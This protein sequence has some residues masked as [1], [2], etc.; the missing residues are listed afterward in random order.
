MADLFANRRKVKAVSLQPPPET[1]PIIIN[2]VSDNDDNSKWD[3]S[4]VELEKRLDLKGFQIS[5]QESDGNCLFRAFSE[6][7]G[8]SS[9]Q[10]LQYR[11]KAVNF[12][13]A[14]AVDFQPFVAESAFEFQQYLERIATPNTWGDEPEL[15]ALSRA[16]EVNVVIFQSD[17]KAEIFIENF[18]QEFACICLSYHGKQHYNLVRLK[19]NCQSTSTLVEVKRRLAPLPPPRPP[20]PCPP[21]SEER[22]AAHKKKLSGL[23]GKELKF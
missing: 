10:H 3:K 23:F 6:A 4:F 17:G 9:E 22:S 18:D 1:A 19:G 12:M 7:H 16:L 11:A 20:S 21:A 15:Q 14:N 8:G 13:R 5:A 2:R